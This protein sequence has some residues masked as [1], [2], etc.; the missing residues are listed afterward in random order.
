MGERRGVYGGLVGKPEGKRELGRS[1]C[2]WENNIKINLEDLG[3]GSMNWS[4]LAQDRETW[5]VFISIGTCI[6]LIV[7]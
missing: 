1:G 3:Q 4:E 5:Q 7:E 2:R 6:I